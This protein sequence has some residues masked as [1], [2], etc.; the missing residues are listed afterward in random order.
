[1]KVEEF[2]VVITKEKEFFVANM[3]FP[4]GELR[5]TQGKS[6]IEC[7]DMI[8]DLLKIRLEDSD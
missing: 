4:D 2:K 1:M 7:Y 5:V 6:I 8:A 3:V